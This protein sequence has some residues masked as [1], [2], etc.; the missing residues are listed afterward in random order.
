MSVELQRDGCR[1]AHPVG[2]CTGGRGRGDG[3][4]HDDA[5]DVY[6]VDADRQPARG[7]VLGAAALDLEEV[8]SRSQ[9]VLGPDGL[10]VKC[11]RRV[12][13]GVLGGLA[14]KRDPRDAVRGRLG[15][16]QADVG[17]S[18][19]DVGD[20]T[21]RA[22]VAPR[23]AGAQGARLKRPAPAPCEARIGLL[24][25]ADEGEARGLDLLGIACQ[26]D[27]VPLER[28]GGLTGHTRC[29]PPY[30]PSRNRRRRATSSTRRPRP[31]LQA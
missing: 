31:C 15:A 1:S 23:P 9:P 30:R 28:V 8:T 20:S 19:R 21:G 13:V 16:D 29:S 24:D 18:E 7:S 25:P 26:V 27:G 12:E 22:G 11:A 3:V 6:R 4:G 2:G 10:L 5:R 17:T 14:V